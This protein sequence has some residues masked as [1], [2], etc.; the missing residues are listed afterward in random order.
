MFQN[1]MTLFSDRAIVDM[2]KTISRLTLCKIFIKSVVLWATKLWLSYSLSVN[3]GT[4]VHLT[5]LKIMKLLKMLN[6]FIFL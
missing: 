1:H 6:V 5:T 3:K 4:I 2:S